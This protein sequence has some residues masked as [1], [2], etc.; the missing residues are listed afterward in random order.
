MSSASTSRPGRTWSGVRSGGAEPLPAPGAD[1]LPP[2]PAPGEASA[3]ARVRA[4]RRPRVRVRGA[5][6]GSGPHRTPHGTVSAP[7][8]AW[9]RSADAP[10]L[11]RRPSSPFCAGRPSSPTSG[12]PSSPTS[13]RRARVGLAAEAA[14]PPRQ[15]LDI[16]RQGA[17]STCTARSPG[18]AEGPGRFR[19]TVRRGRRADSCRSAQI[20]EGAAGRR[21]RIGQPLVPP[22]VTR[23]TAL[24]GPTTR[25]RGHDRDRGR[26]LSPG[27]DRDLRGGSAGCLER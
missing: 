1:H 25:H 24:S 23:R 20:V 16:G 6:T 7:G 26:D 22:R 21:S 9:H 10:S 14:L 17:P 2:R 13:G 4:G 18:G 11:R 8:R 5:A 27:G 15:A 3:R 12:R 19:Q